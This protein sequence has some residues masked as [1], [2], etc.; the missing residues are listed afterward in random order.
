MVLSGLIGKH[1][2]EI[3]GN[4]SWLY[5]T[6]FR[7]NPTLEPMPSLTPWGTRGANRPSLGIRGCEKRPGRFGQR[8]QSSWESSWEYLPLTR[9]AAKRDG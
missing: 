8:G 6:K 2:L 5:D 3:L 1:Q 7:S 4:I 9:K